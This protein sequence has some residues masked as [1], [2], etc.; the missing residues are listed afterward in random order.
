MEGNTVAS[1]NR[2]PPN[3]GNLITVLSIDGGGIRG[4]IPGV[5]LAYLEKQLQVCSYKIYLQIKR[6]FVCNQ[7]NLLSLPENMYE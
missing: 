7:N 6:E 4:I 1:K 3:S 5:I 2:P